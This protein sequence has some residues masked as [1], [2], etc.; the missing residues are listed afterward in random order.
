MKKLF[1]VMLALLTLL[2]ALPAAVWAAPIDTADGW[3]RAGITSAIEKGFVPADLQGS[4]T[5]VI[6][7]A[8]FCRLA[9]KWVEYALG[10]DIDAVL[11]EKG[12]TRKPG[13]FSE[14]MEYKLT[15]T[16]AG[17]MEK[18]SRPIFFTCCTV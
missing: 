10:K 17:G 4:Y 2:S 6:T 7:R 13:A 9:V 5:N 8:E 14:S 3:A 16:R 11:A 18:S 12:L 15:V 1:S